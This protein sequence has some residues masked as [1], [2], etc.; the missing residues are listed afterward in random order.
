MLEGKILSILFSLIFLSIYSIGQN[1]RITVHGFVSDIETKQKLFANIQVISDSLNTT[2]LKV[3]SDTVKGYSFQIENKSKYSIIISLDDYFFYE[4]TIDL[5][6]FSSNK[7][8]VKNIELKKIEISVGPIRLNNVYF[9]ENKFDL[10][11]DFDSLLTKMIDFLKFYKEIMLEVGGHTDSKEV[12]KDSVL[13]YNRASVIQQFL[14]K[15]GINS[16]RITVKDYKNNLPIADEKKEEGRKQ[17][18]RVEF[19]LYKK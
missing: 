3:S 16:N 14:I 4:D 15:N 17:N 12:K 5:R 8:L 1:N 13:G 10:K 2:L 19:K 18:R 11:P 9:D 6:S 7:D